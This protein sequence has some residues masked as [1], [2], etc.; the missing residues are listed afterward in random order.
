MDEFEVGR[1]ARS[2]SFWTPRFRSARVTLRKGTN[3]PAHFAITTFDNSKLTVRIFINFE[4]VGLFWGQME[5]CC[6]PRTRLVSKALKRVNFADEIRV[7]RLTQWRL[8]IASSKHSKKDAVLWLPKDRWINFTKKLSLKNV[9]NSFMSK[10]VGFLWQVSKF[11]KCQL[12]NKDRQ[13]WRK[14]SVKDP[15]AFQFKFYVKSVGFCVFKCP[16]SSA[17][18]LKLETCHSLT[19]LNDKW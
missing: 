16:I 3:L 5:V 19:P 7:W 6:V 15:Q 4:I 13:T 11:N 1:D 14:I 8:T 18:E 17:S 10:H 9:W 2:G 12:S